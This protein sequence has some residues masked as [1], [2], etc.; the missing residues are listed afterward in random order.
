M[1][2]LTHNQVAEKLKVSRSQLYILRK[3]A[4]FPAHIHPPGNP[5]SPRWKSEDID[6]Y[7]VCDYDMERFNAGISN[8]S[9]K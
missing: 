1:S 3:R 4:D 7:I 2:P 8:K 9:E 5:G 6:R